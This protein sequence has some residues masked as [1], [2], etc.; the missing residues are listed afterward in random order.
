ML[1]RFLEVFMRMSSFIAS[2]RAARLSFAALACAATVPAFAG[3]AFSAVSKNTTSGTRL[4]AFGNATVEA[5]I[6]NE[7]GRLEYKES[8]LGSLPKGSI[9]V[10]TDGGRTAKLYNVE[11]HTCGD[12]PVLSSTPTGM[13]AQ[14]AAL[15][16][17][18]NVAVNKT[19][20]EKGPKLQGSATRHLRY[21]TAYDVHPSGPQ[22]KVLHGSIESEVWVAPALTDPAFALWLNAAPHTGNPDAD[23][24]IAEAMGDAKG[25]ALKRVQRT[26]LRL[27]GGKEQVSTTTMEVTRLSMQRPSA[28]SLEPPFV[29]RVG[30]SKE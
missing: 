27:E 26:S 8:G 15:T 7:H 12:V 18:D 30:P 20:D 1:R 3:A 29:C 17:Y 4:P 10:T 2:R 13:R 21:T 6:D 11:E 28:K 5:F 23:R 14:A 22:A 24:K 16:S 19:L 9:V 25:A